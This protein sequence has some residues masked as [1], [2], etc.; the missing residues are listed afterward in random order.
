MNETDSHGRRIEPMG[1][2]CECICNDSKRHWNIA[3][4]M[5]NGC[6]EQV[7]AKSPSHGEM[8]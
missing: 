7:R 4:P 5:C 6:A 2:P 3:P 1:F 8:E